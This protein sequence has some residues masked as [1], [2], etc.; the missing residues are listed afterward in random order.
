MKIIIILNYILYRSL[1]FSNFGHN[2][3]R[4]TVIFIGED[5]IQKSKFLCKKQKHMY[6]LS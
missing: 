2:I 5:E 6:A 1:F 3:N 4:F